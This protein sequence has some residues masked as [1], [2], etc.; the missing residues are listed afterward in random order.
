MD[1]KIFH[2]FGGG[3]GGVDFLDRNGR[4]IDITIVKFI[5][6]SLISIISLQNSLFKSI[7]LMERRI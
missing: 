1:Y 7:N 6:F 3:G 5:I 2:N 4:W